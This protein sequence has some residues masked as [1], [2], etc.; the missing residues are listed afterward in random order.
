VG[1]MFRF[2]I[3]FFLLLF[4]IFFLKHKGIKEGEEGG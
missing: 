1:V 3:S 4:A 2:Y